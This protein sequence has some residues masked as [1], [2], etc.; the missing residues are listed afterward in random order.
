MSIRKVLLSE[1]CTIGR[2]SSPRPIKDEKFFSGGTIPW[3]KIA[4]ATASGKY[5][6]TTKQFVNDYGAS[7]SR[8]LLPGAL[9]L[10]ASGTLGIPRFL[11][12]EACVHDGWLYFSNY[13]GIDP[14]F[15]YYKLMTLKDYFNSIA[16]GAAIQNINTDLVRNTEIDL[17]DVLTQRKITDILIA[18]DSLLDAN[19]RRI[20]LLEESAKILYQEWFVKLRFPGYEMVKIVNG[21]PEGWSR[22]PLSEVAIVNGSSI[23]NKETPEMIRYIDIASVEMGS[24]R[25]LNEIAFAEAPGRARRSVRHGDVIWSCVRPNRKSYALIWEP[26]QNVIASTGFAVITSSAIPFSYLYLATTTDDF[27]AYLTNRA[28]GAT[29]PAVTAKDFEAAELLQPSTDVLDDFHACVEPIFALQEC[30]KLQNNQLVEARDA[31][32]P[33]LM[34]GQLAV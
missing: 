22:V 8:K 4:N 2:G 31:L 32:L 29:Y 12:V 1:V 3:V 16:Y 10:P 21:V 28:T 6:Y 20:D 7:F 19:R 26:G 27:V 11:G 5:I 15:L 14:E 9:I 17:P 34:S 13:E 30:L 25:P 23:S 24:I 18:Y 33:K